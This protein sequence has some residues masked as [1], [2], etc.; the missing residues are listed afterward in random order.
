[1]IAREIMEKITDAT[2]MCLPYFIFF[3]VLGRST[4]PLFPCVWIM[5]TMSLR[6]VTS[7]SLS[8]IRV[9]MRGGVLRVEGK[10]RR[11]SQC[12]RVTRLRPMARFIV[13]GYMV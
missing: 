3:M 10:M 13:P 4:I 7:A 6:D 8:M 9:R 1:M 5:A 12:R 2:L 11:A